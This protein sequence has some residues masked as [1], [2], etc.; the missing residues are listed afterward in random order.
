MSTLQACNI[1]GQFNSKI[2]QTTGVVIIATRS[3]QQYTGFPTVSF[4]ME[5]SIDLRLQ[6]KYI[7]AVDELSV[8]ATTA[9]SI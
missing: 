2:P 6:Q 3:L 7:F 8:S 4:L 9:M 5:E 1:D